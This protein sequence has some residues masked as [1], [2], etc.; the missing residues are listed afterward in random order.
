MESTAGERKQAEQRNSHQQPIGMPARPPRQQSFIY[1]AEAAHHDD[2][3]NLGRFIS[4]TLQQKASATANNSRAGR[5]E[6]I[7]RNF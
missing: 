7:R 3:R 4:L 2:G 1:L 5:T 6:V